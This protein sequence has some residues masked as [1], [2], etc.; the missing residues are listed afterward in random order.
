MTTDYKVAHNFTKANDVGRTHRPPIDITP[1]PTLEGWV[2]ITVF[3]DPSAVY[4]SKDGTEK[5]FVRNGKVVRE[6]FG[7]TTKA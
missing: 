5:M 4:L 1:S 6:K 7:G 2:E 3:G